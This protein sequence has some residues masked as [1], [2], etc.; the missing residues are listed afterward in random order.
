M[1]LNYIDSGRGKPIVLLHG[2]ASSSRYWESYLPLLSKTNRV[3]AV[4]LLGFGRSPQS[5]TDYTAGTHIQAL[6]D[7]LESLGLNQF[8]IAAHSMGALLALKYAV[9]YP[10][11]VTK[12]VLIGMPIYTSP[13][14]A[15]RDITRGKKLLAF[16]YY[17]NTSR[18]LCSLWCYR[19]R[20]VS[21]RLA[22]YY[23]KNKPRHVA[24]DSVLHT[25][26]SYSESLHYII[27]QQT[28]E[29]N[30]NSVHCPVYLFYGSHES[31]IV[32]GN[33]ASLKIDRTHIHTQILEGTHSLTLE[34]PKLISSSILSA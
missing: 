11:E 26:R 4:D 9:A 28:V 31:K 18:I 29:K 5:S 2:M 10:D 14:E 7:T 21:R 20:P 15:R 12:L 25:W 27:E 17:G 19:L 33:L 16:T 8:V 24:E 1:L 6:H 23:L 22:R 13:E 34:Q 3:I 32:L 30:L